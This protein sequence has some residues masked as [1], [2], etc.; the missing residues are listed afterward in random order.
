[1]KK[2]L[3]NNARRK[4]FRERRSS[5]TGFSL[6]ELML[7]LTLG[8]VVTAG[9]V[10]LFVG[11]N[12]TNQLISGQSRLQESARYALDFISR[13]TRNAGFFGCDPERDKLGLTLNADFDQIFE[14]NL[15][16]PVEGFNSV[17]AGNN[18]SDWVPS[19]QTLPRTTTSTSFNTVVA[20]NGIDVS[21]IVPG[22]DVL[23]VRYMLAPGEL[24]A[25]QVSNT[26]NPVVVDDGNVPFQ[27]GDFGL[28]SNCEQAS[29]FHI[30]DVTDGG[31]EITLTRGTGVG[32]FENSSVK[33]LGDLPY[34]GITSNEGAVVAE[35]LTDIY[36]VAQGA[37]T[38]NRGE[39]TT[40]LWRKSGTSAPV[41]L[42]EGI[43]NM[44]VL[45]GVDTDPLDNIPSA[46]RYIPFSAVGN[47]VV[48]SVRVT[49]EA[50]TVDVVSD[51]QE[52]I[53]RSFTQTIS[54][55]NSG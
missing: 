34:G 10:Q 4:S 35:V 19:L 51:S 18:L 54:V 43:S 37:G 17:G 13:S 55:R 47:D 11:N 29:L 25:S 53:A 14:Y 12:R 9:I 46:N 24:L 3:F 26:Q 1:M 6:I 38:N 49:V 21:T 40:A 15:L 31:G 42:V 20:G 22:S 5:Q 23:V 48:R 7:A 27:P 50:N 2:R 39:S 41:E 33:N 32:I 36:F 8:L 28:I 44:Q 30:T 16:V 45:F 52:P